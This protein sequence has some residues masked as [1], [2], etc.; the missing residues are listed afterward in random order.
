MKVKQVELL[1]RRIANSIEHQIK[2][3]VLKVGDKLPSIRSVCREQGVSMSTA[4]Q[5]Y[6]DLE[7]KGLIESRPQSGY[8]V[9]YSH[10]HFPATP[11]TSNPIHDFGAKETEGLIAKVFSELGTQ[12]N[13]LFSMG[14]PDPVLLPVAK[15]NKAL[16]QAM[17]ELPSGG[18]S[19]ERVQGNNK[20]RRQ[21]A[22]G[23]FSWNG[24][25]L[26]DDLV[27]TSGCMNALAYC[28]MALTQRGDTIVME[29]P[30]YFGMLQLAQSLG[31]KV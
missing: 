20:L 25:L 16:V 24:K 19:Y 13:L 10:K 8:Y 1:Y 2:N 22:K 17:R 28:L 14:V 4:L 30:V 31:L 21:I 7:R 23:A 5:A 12:K 18:T 15:I 26:E 29:S 6:Y 27:T 11:E 9:S 3:D